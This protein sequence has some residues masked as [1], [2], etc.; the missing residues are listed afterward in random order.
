M[1]GSG[2]TWAG[3]ERMAQRLSEGSL[4]H[5]Y[6]GT[7]E[8]QPQFWNSAIQY[9]NEAL[10]KSEEAQQGTSTCVFALC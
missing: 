1:S 6:L 10:S 3:W 8:A 5:F 4:V 7:P 2:Y 9:A